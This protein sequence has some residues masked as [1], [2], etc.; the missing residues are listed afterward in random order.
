[1]QAVPFHHRPPVSRAVLGLGPCSCN[2]NCKNAKMAVTVT[3][4][5]R[6]SSSLT[7]AISPVSQV[8]HSVS[9]PTHPSFQVGKN[10]S[11][12]S[13]NYFNLSNVSSGS[14]NG[15]RPML[16]SDCG[17]ANL[18]VDL[19]SSAV[20]AFQ[21]MYNFLYISGKVI[22]TSESNRLA[23]DS[24]ILQSTSTAHGPRIGCII[25][26]FFVNLLHPIGCT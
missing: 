23:V 20:L 17:Q 14:L 9:G 1:M 25:F 16:N 2:C 8:S 10:S 22:F 5:F 12:G 26:G 21:W 4:I 13:V 6:S 11:V 24:R 15:V 3:I 19:E 7:E 18:S